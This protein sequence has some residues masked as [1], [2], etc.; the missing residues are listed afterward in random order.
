M[1]WF[2]VIKEILSSDA[3]SFGFVVFVLLLIAWAIH[4]ITAYTTEW[5]MR[6]QGLDKLEGK[7]ENLAKYVIKKTYGEA[8]L[9][10]NSLLNAENDSR[11]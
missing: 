2:D 9:F 10:M 11:N 1:N 8:K 3:G 6:A 4:K 7:V 5:R